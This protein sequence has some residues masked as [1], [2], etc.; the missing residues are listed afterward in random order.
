MLKDALFSHKN[1]VWSTPQDL[2]DALDS[3]FHFDLDVCADEHNHKC[4][5]YFTVE[6]DGLTQSWE[7][8]R[9]WCNPPYSKIKQWV[10]KCYYEGHLPNTVVVML[11]PSRTDTKWFQNY[12][13]HRAEI[14]FIKG[15]LRFG[16]ATENA[17]FPSM[18]CIF[19]GPSEA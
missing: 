12:I 2:F 16:G 10:R 3:E 6:D 7:G 11:V 9:V 18:L 13:L 8:H 4:P 14:R 15:R 1:D 19:R 17:P 5:Q